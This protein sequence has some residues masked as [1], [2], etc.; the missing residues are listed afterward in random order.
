MCTDF[1]VL[2]RH[3]LHLFVFYSPGETGHDKADNHYEKAE[4]DRDRDRERDRER[5]RD[6][7]KEDGRDRDRD[8]D[9]DRE[10]DRRMRRDDSAPYSKSKRGNLCIIYLIKHL[11]N[12]SVYCLYKPE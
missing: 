6:R 4:R 12:N 3:V 11:I 7:D 9:R 8:R 10:R 1:C 5:E 2:S